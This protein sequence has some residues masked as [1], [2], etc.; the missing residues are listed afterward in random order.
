MFYS[1]YINNQS[2]YSKEQIVDEM[3]Y[4]TSLGTEGVGRTLNHKVRKT[5]LVNNA[6]PYY[7]HTKIMQFLQ[8]ART[9]IDGLIKTDGQR[10]LS[11]EELYSEF[12]IPKRN[13]GHRT[14]LAPCDELKTLQRRL[15]EILKNNY[16]ILEHNAAHAYVE[17]RAIVTNAQ[18]H[19]N[20]YNFVNTDLSNFFPSIKREHIYDAMRRNRNLYAMTMWIT[21][22][23]MDTFFD[24]LLYNDALPQGS[25][26]SPFISNIVM[27]P[28]DHHI[29]EYLREHHRDIIY[30]RYADDMTFS[31]KLPIKPEVITGE[32]IQKAKELAYSNHDFIQINPEKT[33]YTTYR[34]KNRV[35]GIKIN[36]ENKLSIGY[37][38][39]QQIKTDMFALL[40]AKENGTNIEEQHKQE[41]VG[42]FSYL[43]AV[44]PDYAK[45]LKRVWARKFNIN[46]DV[47]QYIMKDPN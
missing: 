33:R 38:E 26:A 11:I 13:G 2:R 6:N 37:K 10:D 44:E 22:E 32:I 8:Y 17:E 14:I 43:H 36:A 24:I 45:H 30:T 3:E 47:V 18:V 23:Q 42:M 28:L 7:S 16:E 1:T 5:I 29:T 25:A 15:V 46:I 41:V 4:L 39:K 35:T 27:V 34:G 31:S 9:V 20:N 21:T 12:T 40:V 19:V